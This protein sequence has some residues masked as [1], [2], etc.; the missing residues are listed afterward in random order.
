[1]VESVESIVQI[2][3]LTKVYGQFRALSSCTFDVNSGDILGLLGPNGAG[4]STLL[5]VL[6]GAIQPTSGKACLF[7]FDCFRQSTAIHAKLAYLPGDARLFR[8][9][10]GRDTLR[11]FAGLRNASEQ[12]YFQVAERLELD[13]SRKV[14][15]MSTGM[16][17]KLAIAITLAAPVP[18]MILDEP[19]ANLDPSVR[20]EILTMLKER[21]QAGTSII[22]SSHV[23]SE[24]EEVCNRVVL[25]RKGEVVHQEDLKSLRDQ[26]RI[27]AVTREPLGE[28][29]TE[30][31]DRVIVERDNSGR[32]VLEVKENLSA[33][34]QWLA[35]HFLVDIQVETIGLRRVYQQYHGTGLKSVAK[36]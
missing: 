14:G 17:Q 16:R 22:F 2:R 8:R 11:F 3:D 23:L 34:L 1:M 13:F 9:M 30:L 27:I 18:L 35:Q 24:I 33:A 26:H 10:T 25:L 5:R 21:R 31:Q 15:M 20:A 36:E 12:S 6:V 4:K 28:L 7:G 19:T 29:P 32:Y